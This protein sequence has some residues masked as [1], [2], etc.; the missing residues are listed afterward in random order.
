MVDDNVSD[1]AW[2]DS[3]VFS[4]AF[5]SSSRYDSQR[6]S[7]VGLKLETDAAR[8]SGQPRQRPSM[9]GLKLGGWRADRPMVS[10]PAWLDSNC[11]TSIGKARTVRSA[12]Q[13]GW[14][15]TLQNYQQTEG[16]DVRQRPSMVRLNRAGVTV[17][18]PAWL[19]SNLFQWRWDI[20]SG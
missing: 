15:Q 11:N 17:S 6:P 19:D 18:D 12:T 9:V 13:H 3:N 10:D 8:E 2:L 1:P 7:M 20:G 14:T 5:C 4:R 16:K